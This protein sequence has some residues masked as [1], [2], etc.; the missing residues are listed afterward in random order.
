M[1]ADGFLQLP[2]SMDMDSSDSGGALPS[3][4]DSSICSELRGTSIAF[5]GDVFSVLF[6]AAPSDLRFARRE[7]IDRA[8]QQWAAKQAAAHGTELSS[9]FLAGL[10]ERLAQ[11]ERQ[12]PP[13]ISR[14]SCDH[15]DRVALHGESL[16][17]FYRSVCEIAQVGEWL[18]QYQFPYLPAFF[19][20]LVPVLQSLQELIRL[21]HVSSDMQAL[22]EW[23]PRFNSSLKEMCSEYEELVQ[24]K[25]DMFGDMLS[26]GGLSWKAIGLP[27][28]NGLILHTQQWF[29]STTET[30]LSRIARIY[31]RRANSAAAF[32]KDDI[33]IDDLALCSSQLIHSVFGCSVLCGKRLTSLAPHILYIVSEY[34]H[35]VVGKSSSRTS[36]LSTLRGKSLDSCAMRAMH[37]SENLVKMLSYVRA[38][39]G[40]DRSVFDL[41]A[42]VY[43]S[44]TVVSG[45]ESLVLSLVDL[46]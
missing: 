12:L 15:R 7:E 24:G 5:N 42:K 41:E 2:S 20:T 31:E 17:E 27:V 6:H 9:Q 4:M 10:R 45:L 8:V 32:G 35:W 21:A 16:C 11:L 19:P 38:T 46:S 26:Q 39:L 29:E 43:E 36:E 25:R 44:D 40:G 37:Q 33:S 28:D 18:Y 23:T 30:C 1:I 14:I 34:A 3:T 22:V 13:I